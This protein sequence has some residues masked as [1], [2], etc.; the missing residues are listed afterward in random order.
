MSVGS[1]LIPFNDELPR[2]FFPSAC[3]SLP[4]IFVRDANACALPQESFRLKRLFF[5]GRVNSVVR[6]VIG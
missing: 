6:F 2:P 4:G 5:D 1:S 3:F